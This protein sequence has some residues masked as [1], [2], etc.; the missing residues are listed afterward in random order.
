MPVLSTF[1][2]ICIGMIASYFTTC[3]VFEDYVFGDSG[4]NKVPSKDGEDETRKKTGRTGTHTGKGKKDGRPQG[5][6]EQ[7][8]KG[9]PAAQSSVPMI[10]RRKPNRA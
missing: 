2:I 4:G 6:K 3:V 7:D 9:K 5:G 10:R 8:K 1:S